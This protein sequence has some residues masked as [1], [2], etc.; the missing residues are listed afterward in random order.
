MVP[1]LLWLY[2][3]AV[4]V[5]IGLGAGFA[6]LLLFFPNLRSGVARFV[7]GSSI[8]TNVGPVVTIAA[9]LTLMGVWLALRQTSRRARIVWTTAFLMLGSAV[10]IVDL[11]LVS[12]SRL[13]DALRTM[14]NE[15]TMNVLT[16]SAAN[17]ERLVV[18]QAEVLAS[19]KKLISATQSVVEESR[20]RTT[21]EKAYGFLIPVLP[22]AVPESASEMALPLEAENPSQYVLLGATAAIE[23]G[24]RTGE[25]I[26][27]LQEHLRN[28]TTVT[29]GDIGPMSKKP[30][31]YTLTVQK[32]RDNYFHIAIYSQYVSLT[33][34][35]VVSWSN[36]KWNTDYS[37][38]RTGDSQWIHQVAGDFPFIEQRQ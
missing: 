25:T 17:I 26:E 23:E 15:I 10:V 32:G 24:S 9:L 35:L 37:L 2:R 27:Q 20:N 1:A 3:F 11:S 36:G 14:Q 6:V 22:G 30:I 5:V 33:E 16:R 4:G 7:A 34:L 21:A 29:L 8:A 31:R 18:L 13:D 12:K 19:Q 28:T 38:I